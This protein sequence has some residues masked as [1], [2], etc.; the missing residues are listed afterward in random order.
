MAYILNIIA[1]MLLL[2]MAIADAGAFNNEATLHVPIKKASASNAPEGWGITEW[3]GR[4]EFEVIETEIGS[5]L[6][7][8]SSSTS[9]ALYKDMS[10]DIKEYPALNWK[11]KVE[12]LP[13]GADARR[14][15][16]DDQA[17][18]LYVIFPR[19]PAAV[20]SRVI[21][22]IWDTSA[23]S[24]AYLSSRKSRNTRYVVVKSGPS[25]IG[26]WHQETKDVYADYRR[27][28]SEDPPKAGRVSVMIDTDD[29]KGHA[30][31]FIGNIFFSKKDVAL[32]K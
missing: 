13:H 30:E 3:K 22:Y 31:S 5:T 24:G 12:R 27:L 1:A 10:F 25:E 18:Q 7:L 32:N 29:T 6:H 11:W 16:T 19:W 9:T 23:P 20:N 2:N 17:L 21:G 8:K 4:A 14:G 15:A 28:F 26:R